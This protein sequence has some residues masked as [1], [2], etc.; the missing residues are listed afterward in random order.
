MFNIGNV[1]NCF[2]SEN[3]ITMVSFVINMEL[4]IVVRLIKLMAYILII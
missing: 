2:A 3:V 1:V 4:L